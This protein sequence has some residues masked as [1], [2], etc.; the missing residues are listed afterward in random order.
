MKS[1]KTALLAKLHFTIVNQTSKSENCLE[2]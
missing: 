2:T 1:E